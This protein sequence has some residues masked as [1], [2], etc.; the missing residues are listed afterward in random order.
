MEKPTHLISATG[1]TMVTQEFADEY[2]EYYLSPIG[3][4]QPPKVIVRNGYKE[5]IARHRFPI[6][7]SAQKKDNSVERNKLN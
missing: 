2:L 5:D 1:K 7:P 6:D 3:S 4:R